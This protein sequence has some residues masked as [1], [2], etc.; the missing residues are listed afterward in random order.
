MENLPDNS[1]L[2]TNICV[3]GLDPSLKAEDL[4]FMFSKFGDIKSCKV[5]QDP[6]SGKSKGYGYVWFS[7]E[8]SCKLALSAKDLPY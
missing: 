8:S 1:C 5:A 3:K 4:H 7:E 6:K 2:L